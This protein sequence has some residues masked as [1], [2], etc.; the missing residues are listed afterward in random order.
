[1][2]LTVRPIEESEFDT[3]RAKMARGFGADLNPKD[4]P[5]FLREI[6]EFDRTVAA[7]DGDELVGTGGAFS[8]DVTVPGGVLPMAGTTIISVQPTH[9]RRGVLRAMM[10]A[11]L[12]DVRHRGE[13]LA[14]LWASES[15]IYG[16]FGYGQATDLHQV[17]LDA[18]T[19][20]FR[21]DPPA[22]AVRLVESDEA[23][24]KMEAVYERVRPTRPGML[25]RSAAWWTGR[26]MYDPEHRRDGCSSKRFAV[27]TGS[28]G[29]EGYAVY[30]QK[31]K[32]DDFPE[33][34]VQV[35]ELMAAT[36]DAHEAL[37]RYLTRIDL[38]PRVEYWN[39][40]VDDELPWRVVEA[41]RVR[42]YVWDA[43]WI[44]LIDIPRALE[45]RSYGAEG[46]VVLGVRDPFMPDN[47]GRYLLE[48]GP[49]GA[50]CSMTNDAADLELDVNALGALYL[51]GQ[52]ISTLV[53]AGWVRGDPRLLATAGAL[54]AWSPQPW[55]PEIF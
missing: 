3:F 19:I 44:R 54:F 6:I 2:D 36:P 40:P 25:S 27:Y 14:G 37:W 23:R 22:G 12:D 8:F 33:G 16:R 30:R 43:L 51:G 24:T 39:L 13:P 15:T 9:R 5:V 46:R 47:D 4:E 38:F 20:E 31:H 29:V 28:A 48:A 34:E 52:S 55:C 11:H 17:K 53:R 32:W 41:R 42:R 26:M 7:F 35:S 45:G 21:G 1:M 18:S 49:D 50:K 10:T